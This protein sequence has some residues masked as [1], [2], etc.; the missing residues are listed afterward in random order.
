MVAEGRRVSFLQA[1]G[2]LKV[3]L[4]P[5]DDPTPTHTQAPPTGLCVLVR[6]KTGSEVWRTGR[7]EGLGEI[8]REEVGTEMI[9]THFQ[10]VC[11][12]QT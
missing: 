12:Y 2:F 9:K 11:N 10:H 6:K 8:K 1:C 7:K 5:V 4:A 3:A